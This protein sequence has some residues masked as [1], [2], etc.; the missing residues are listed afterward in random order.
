MPDSVKSKEASQNVAGE[1]Y[2]TL[3]TEIS[4]KLE[5]VGISINEARSFARQ[6]IGAYPGELTVDILF[7]YAILRWIFARVIM[8]NWLFS[9]ARTWKTQP[10][11]LSTLKKG[12]L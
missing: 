6:A 9:G 3:V 2:N 5:Q 4:S 10:P 1:D 11:C 12:I 7:G 8:R